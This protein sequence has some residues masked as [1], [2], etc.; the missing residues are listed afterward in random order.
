MLINKVVSQVQIKNKW[1]HLRKVWKQLFEYKTRLGYD[2]NTGKIDETNE[3]WERKIK[4][5]LLQRML[6]TSIFYN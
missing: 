3:W 4:V 5:S 6:T 2:P 1:D